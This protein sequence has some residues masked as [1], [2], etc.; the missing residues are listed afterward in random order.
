M[1]KLW[2]RGDKEE[3]PASAFLFELLTSHQDPWMGRE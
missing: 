3:V 2:K 1:I